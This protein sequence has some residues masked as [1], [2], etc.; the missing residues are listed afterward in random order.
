M[1]LGLL[2][3]RLDRGD[4]A[5]A[6]FR[7][8]IRCDERFP[9]AHYQLGLVLEKKGRTADAVS[10]LEAASRLD[11][12]YPDPQYALSRVH[13]RSGDGER[14]DRALALFQKLKKEKGQTGSGR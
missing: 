6:L 7:E 2:L 12:A 9:Q 10:E 4:E 8:S 3:S 11:P 14:A 13:R 1:N 5:E